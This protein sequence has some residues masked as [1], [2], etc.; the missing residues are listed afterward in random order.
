MPLAT[1]LGNKKEFNCDKIKSADSSWQIFAADGY[2]YNVSPIY[3]IQNISLTF[4]TNGA[5]YT[6]SY[7][8][9]NSFNKTQT[10]TTPKDGSAQA[11]ILI[12]FNQVISKSQIQVVLI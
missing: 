9:D 5:D 11:Y 8:K 4:L 12:V 3:G 6:I 1:N 7:S 10:F 2:F